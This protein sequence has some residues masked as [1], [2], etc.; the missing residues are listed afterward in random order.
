MGEK[1]H[2]ILEINSDFFVYKSKI[3]KS[4]DKI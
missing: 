2:C 3:Y 1:L 4:K